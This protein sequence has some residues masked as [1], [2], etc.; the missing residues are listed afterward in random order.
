[1]TSPLLRYG[2]VSPDQLAT[3]SGLDLL[4]GM[5]SGLYPHAQ[6]MRTMN[7]RLVQADPGFVVFEGETREDFLNPLGTI[8]GGWGATLLDSCMACCVHTLLQPGQI[9]TTAEMKIN[10]V[11]PLLPDSGIV[12]AEGK[13][14]HGG[15]RIAT[16]D[17]RLIDAKGRLIAH[18]TETCFIFDAPKPAE[19]PKTGS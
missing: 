14:I 4:R 6:I 9:Y 19:N 5:V 13:V 15:N 11:R 7:Y 16:S 3:T 12:R 18:G 1:M 17:G 2:I 8:H 10:Y